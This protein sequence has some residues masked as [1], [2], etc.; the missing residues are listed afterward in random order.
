V[1]HK[2]E[3]LLARDESARPVP[4]FA[5]HISERAIENVVRTL[6][7]GYVG[8]GPLVKQFET[9][10]RK[11]LRTPHAI[12]VN[13]GTSAITLA[14]ALIGVG[15]G[16]E[17]ITTAQTFVATSQ[18]ILSCGARP[19]YA[20]VQYGTGNLDPED[21]AHRITDRTRAIL[22]V[23]WAGYPC[24][25]AEILAIASRHGLPV[26]EDAAQAF[27]ATY[28]GTHVGSISTMTCFSFQAVKQ[29]T[30]VDGG[31]LCVL[32]EHVAQ[33]ARRR[34]W[35]GIDRAAR[36]QS[37][38]GEPEWNISEV[39]Y[40]FHMNDVTASLGIAHLAD[41]PRVLKRLRSIERR[42]RGEFAT[43]SGLR[44]FD[45]S[46]DRESACWTF[47]AHV[48]CREDFVRALQSRGIEA[49]VVHL[50]IDRNVVLGPCRND[51]P[52]LT[53][54]TSSMICVPLHYRLTDEDVERVIRAVSEGW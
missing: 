46:D 5:V 39:G 25:L 51:L 4:I 13:S 35:F 27:G 45:S 32:D 26:V 34:R 38:L 42:Y 50:R 23:H 7:G 52:N 17:V 21:I 54:L 16:D 29:L 31:M 14:L 20:D 6:R 41:F 18:A 28:K 12:A 24:D 47:C 1:A 49:S 33:A 40:K 48:D 19:V 37:L 22:P 44:P 9:K 10:V 2:K 8:D 3:S 15:P 11:Y 43:V 30:T 36:G 53:A